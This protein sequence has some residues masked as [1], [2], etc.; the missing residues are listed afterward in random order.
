MIWGETT[1][2]EDLFMYLSLSP[3]AELLPKFV[4]WVLLEDDLYGD[5][6]GVA[7]FACALED[8]IL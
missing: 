2:V 8:Y 5:E 1:F 4:I 3:K 6:K 7:L